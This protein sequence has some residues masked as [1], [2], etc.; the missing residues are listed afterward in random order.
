MSYYMIKFNLLYLSN[1]YHDNSPS[2]LKKLYMLNIFPAC[3]ICTLDVRTVKDFSIAQYFLHFRLL[4][5]TTESVLITR[6][7][8]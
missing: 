1:L 2:H 7:F 5:R 3:N 4:N 8:D 6:V